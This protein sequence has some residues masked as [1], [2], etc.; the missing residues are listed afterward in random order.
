[1]DWE[2]IP[3]CYDCLSDILELKLAYDSSYLLVCTAE[4]QL[5]VFTNTNNSFVSQPPRKIHFENECPR[6]V[7]FCD[8]NRSFVVCM[9]SHNFYQFYLP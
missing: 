3:K 4:S 1:M 9:D 7:E 5:F 8:D 6:S 2:E